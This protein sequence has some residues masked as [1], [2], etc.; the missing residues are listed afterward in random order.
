MVR[1]GLHPPHHVLESITTLRW[2]A[3]KRVDIQYQQLL[4][5][6]DP[7]GKSARTRRPPKLGEAIQRSRSIINLF[8]QRKVE[9]ATPSRNSGFIAAGDR[10]S[11]AQMVVVTGTF[12]KDFMKACHRSLPEHCV[13][14]YARAKLSSSRIAAQ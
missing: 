13:P 11:Y 5:G 3:H 9:A 2:P 4:T 1:S 10:P 6:I 12:E 7:W 8:R 14:G